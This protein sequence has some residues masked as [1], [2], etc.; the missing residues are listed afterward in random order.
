[1]EID[2]DLDLLR[3]PPP[4]PLRDIDV[5]RLR[6]LWLRLVLRLREDREDDAVVPVLLRRRMEEVAV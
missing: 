4:P 5:P 1:M 3:P 2:R 6:L